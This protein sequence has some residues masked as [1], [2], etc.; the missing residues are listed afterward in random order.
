MHEK[1]TVLVFTH[2]MLLEST[3]HYFS[4]DSQVQGR[5]WGLRE[6]DKN[7]TACLIFW[8]GKQ[9][10]VTARCLDVGRSTGNFYFS[11][12]PMGTLGVYIS[13]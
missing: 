3:F 1:L 11:I 5:F 7:S 9:Q 8:L 6:I 13:R 4:K 10:I 2:N 12:D